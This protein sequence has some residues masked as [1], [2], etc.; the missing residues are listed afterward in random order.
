M[1]LGNISTYCLTHALVDATCAAT[2]FAIAALGQHKPHLLFYMIVLYN[3]VAFATQPLFGLA[4]DTFDLPVTAA[5]A[6][7]L[8]VA[9]ATLLLSVPF[10]TALIT[11]VGNALFHVGGGVVSLQLA[12]GRATLPGIY[13]APGALG[14]DDRHR[15]RQERVF[16]RLALCRT[17]AGIRSAALASAQTGG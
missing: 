1:I 14:A 10:L 11:G 6:G 4:V 12:S 8:L 17:T 2:L 15:G 7:A 9:A 5:V 13:V 3:V 16:H